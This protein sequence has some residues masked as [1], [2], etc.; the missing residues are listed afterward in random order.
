MGTFL[1]ENNNGSNR[2]LYTDLR[3]S[4]GTFYGCHNYNYRE[5]TKGEEMSTKTDTLQ[6]LIKLANV[7]YISICNLNFEYWDCTYQFEGESR[8]LD[9][10]APTM[11]ELEK[12]LIT[13]L[14]E[15][16]KGAL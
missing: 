2:N 6:A 11:R 5:Q 1:R 15:Y 16:V 9:L 7:N 14:K 10:R 3:V 4:I 13:T 12:V 8:F